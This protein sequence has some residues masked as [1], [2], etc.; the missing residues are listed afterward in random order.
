MMNYVQKSSSLRLFF[1]LR[2]IFLCVFSLVIVPLL[3]SCENPQKAKQEAKQSLDQK[4]DQEINAKDQSTQ[5]RQLKDQSTDQS[6]QQSYDLSMA[7]DAFL[8]GVEG[9][10]EVLVTL[11]DQPIENAI[12]S[13]GGTGFSFKT[14][15]EGKVLM[16][17]DTRVAGQ[18]MIIATHSSART[19][20]IEVSSD[21]Q[22]SIVID[23]KSYQASDESSYQI[24][25][26]GEPSHRNSTAQCGHCHLANNDSWFESPHRSSAKNPIVYDLFMGSASAYQTQED[27]VNAKGKWKD[28]RIPGSDERKSQCF[29]EISALKAYQPNCQE[30]PCEEN[31][32]NFGGCADCHAPAI[33]LKGH[34]NL[35]DARGIAYEYGI[36]CDICHRV[37]QIQLDQ[38]AGV[39]GRLILS[40]PA[41]RASPTLGAGGKLPL[42]FG[43]SAD[44]PNPRMGVVQR[45]HYTNGQICA[46]CHFHE[47]HMPESRYQAQNQN[48]WPNQNLPNQSTYQEWQSSPYVDI[49]CNECHMPPKA[50]VANSA[51]LETFPSA[52][53]GIQAGWPRANGDV[54]EHAWWG[55]RQP[56]GKMLEQVAS[57][58]L[59]RLASASNEL[60][61]E[62]ETTNLGAGHFLPTGEPMRHLMTVVEAICTSRPL[63]QL[64]SIG[65][66]AI[67]EIGGYQ[68]SKKIRLNTQENDQT[69][70][71]AQTNQASDLLFW[72]QAQIGDKIRIIRQ[73]NR[74]Y[75]YD[76]FGP[77]SLVDGRFSAQEKGLQK[78]EI[79]GTY[80]I[81]AKD[82]NQMIQTIP[83]MPSP[84]IQD[85][86]WIAYLIA[87]QTQY[88]GKSGFSFARVMVSP[89]F[90]ADLSMVPHFIAT[91]ITRDN[92]LKPMTPWKTQHRFD[93]S[94]PCDGEIQVN[95]KLIY[96]PY[97]YWLAKERGWY[98]WD[99]LMMEVEDVF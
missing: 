3:L 44:V 55:P 8:S 30:N 31:L 11:D 25:D 74:F 91:D 32:S 59:S 86:V 2:S 28:S 52:D 23:L 9:V 10:F 93:L 4:S 36:S 65:G 54:R 56:K 80:E 63:E 27:C 20:S 96:R 87:D 43:P 95:A 46:G 50:K 88:A 13:Q 76:G 60:N 69:Q 57:L 66:D 94:T 78:E 29:F 1:H 39:A 49:P 14:N 26:P 34:Q 6:P 41:E 7:P 98:M 5:D 81:I 82:E 61:I 24:A 71:N 51:N 21:Q 67:H 64:A 15:V 38:P 48:R 45:D 90:N 42:T 47:H 12:V 68:A 70:E 75:D 17:V 99:R 40:K 92:R 83:S 89:E 73:V 53:I 72:P 37:D 22:S 18:L 77:F 16:W 84:T 85:E 97:P 35:L 33:N 19:K 62:L 79:I 58:K